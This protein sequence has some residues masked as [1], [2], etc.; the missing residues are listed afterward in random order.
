[1]NSVN[2]NGNSAILNSTVVA[3]ASASSVIIITLEP[4][5]KSLYKIETPTA[6]RQQSAVPCVSWGKGRTPNSTLDTMS[7]PI[8]AVGWGPLIQLY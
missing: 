4:Q 3:L 7:Y 1:M 8:L 5:V 2:N 6:V